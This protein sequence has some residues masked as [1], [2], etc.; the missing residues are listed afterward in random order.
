MDIESEYIKVLGNDDGFVR[1]EIAF[2]RQAFCDAITDTDDGSLEVE[3]VGSL[4]TGQYFYGSDTIR[5]I[6]RPRRRR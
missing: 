2:D 6:T 1:I 4:T 3:V 5:T